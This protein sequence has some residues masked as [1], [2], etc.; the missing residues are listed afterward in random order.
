MLQADQDDSND[1]RREYSNLGDL[2]SP[3]Y[4]DRYSERHGTGERNGDRNIRY[5]YG[6]RSPGYDQGDKKRSPHRFEV[7]DNRV[8]DDRYGIGN[9]NWRFE[10]QRLPDTA[11]MPERLSP[12]RPKGLPSRPMVR[13]VRDVVGDDAPQ[14][15][16]VDAPKSNNVRVPDTSAPVQVR[17]IVFTEAGNFYVYSFLL[18]FSLVLDMLLPVLM[19]AV[20]I[21][22]KSRNLLCC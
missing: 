18:E 13:P 16:V 12:S 1:S 22:N 15:H 4:D 21:M 8:R 7:V 6:E 3:P 20:F 14:L 17:F 19:F 5:V 11:S 9:Q 2:R 10:D